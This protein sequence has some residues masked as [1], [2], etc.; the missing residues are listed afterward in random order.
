MCMY[1]SLY[2]IYVYIYRYTYIDIHICAPPRMYISH[3]TY[4]LHMH[5]PYWNTQALHP[6]HTDNIYTKNHMRTRAAFALTCRTRSRKPEAIL[7]SGFLL[8]CACLRVHCRPNIR[9]RENAGTAPYE[10]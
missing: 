9:V 1:I 5:L 7:N 8:W 10:L 3:N 6:M 4:I 2:C